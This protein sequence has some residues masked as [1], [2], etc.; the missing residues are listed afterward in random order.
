GLIEMRE[1]SRSPV[2]P[3]S[4][5]PDYSLGQRKAVNEITRAMKTGRFHT[6]VLHGITGS[7]KTEVYLAAAME[8]LRCG[9][10]VIYLV[11]EIAL[12]PQTIDMVK[13]RVPS[14]VAVFHSGLSPKDRA[15]EFMKVAREGVRFVMGTRSAIFSPLKDI[16]LIVVDEE[17]DHSYKQ[18][19]GVPYHA[20]DL[21]ILR[22]RNNRAVVILGSATPSMETYQRIKTAHSEL[23]VMSSR[24][25]PAALPDVEIVD[26]RGVQ[27]PLSEKLIREMN[28]TISQGEQVLLFINRRGF[29]A[30]M[31]CPGCG[32]VLKCSRCDRSLTYHKSKGKALC[33]WCGF[34][35]NLPEIC[36]F[37][38]CLDMKPIGMGTEKILEEVETAFKDK[39]LLRMD[40]DEITTA[41]K[42]SDALDTIR[43]G[44]VDIIVGTQ[45][46]AKG[47]DFPNLTLV[48]V[49]NAEQL[50]Y[51]PDFRAPER[52]F[53]QIVQVAGRAGRRKS[54]TKVI[55]QTSI[56]DHPLIH[57][58]SRYDYAAM[59]ELEQGI[60]KAANF[61]PYS[62]MAR[63]VVTSSQE[64][65]AREFS[66]RIV[67]L[68]RIP[69]VEILGPAPAP[70]S[71]LR[72]RYRWHVILR[73]NKRG[74]LHKAIDVI[75]RIPGAKETDLKIDVD[76]YAMM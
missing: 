1:G 12:T 9:K 3:V 49:V 36:P 38:G 67:S 25:G 19:E 42:L 31:V 24:I 73:S 72:E 35:M 37:C 14:E 29:S 58:I 64:K 75:E 22:A 15:R 70:I 4:A 60:R 2:L 18:D 44:T 6:F 45:M 7:G 17:H 50:L 11:P 10:S 52:T 68:I 46:I 69:E 74:A 59:M 51:M 26:M 32:K 16:G 62:H 76:P 40:S 57:A 39:R 41:K 23:L 43:S 28:E 63:C 66:N 61:P 48:G 8:A 33:H 53:Q 47:H 34:T 56:P 71:F 54:D 13:S 21:S 65:T 30:A 20:R 5:A 55:I 27:G